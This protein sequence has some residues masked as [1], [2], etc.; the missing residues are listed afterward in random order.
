MWAS[1][2]VALFAGYLLLLKATGERYA[3]SGAL[4]YFPM[5]TAILFLATLDI[6]ARMTGETL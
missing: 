2:V 1:S 6:H 3:L 5:I 4:I